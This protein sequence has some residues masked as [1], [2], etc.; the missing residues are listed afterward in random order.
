MDE[1]YFIPDLPQSS[2]IQSLRSRTSSLSR[3]SSIISTG[4]KTSIGTYSQPQ[5]PSQELYP[6]TNGID[7]LLGRRNFRITARP[8]SILSISSFDQPAPP[9]EPYSTANQSTTTLAPTP[10]QDALTERTS[11][12]S[13]PSSPSA[14]DPENANALSQHYTRVVRTIDTNHRAEIARLEASHTDALARLDAL[15]LSTLAATRHDIDAAYR[16]EIKARE[17][18][19][20]EESKIAIQKARNEIENVWE[21]RWRSQMRV[22]ADEALRIEQD[23]TERVR[24][25]IEQ[26]ENSWIQELGRRFPSMTNEWKNVLESVKATRGAQ[27]GG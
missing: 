5:P 24:K 25:S 13:S 17:H 10:S 7:V 12:P 26:E 23:G 15:H 3:A 14:N 1:D 9:Y 27:A 2:D 22:A 11:S 20:T 18:R 4:T 16:K 6:P 8:G 19:L 21:G